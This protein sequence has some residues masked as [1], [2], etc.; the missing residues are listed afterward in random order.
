MVSGTC[1]NEFYHFFVS[2]VHCVLSISAI[3]SKFYLT[4]M[5]RRYLCQRNDSR[6]IEIEL[7]LIS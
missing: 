5:R 3:G 4:N 7:K 6:F 1:I 2:Y